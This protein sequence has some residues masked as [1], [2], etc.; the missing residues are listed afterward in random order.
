VAGDADL[1]ASLPVSKERPA[2]TTTSTP[3]AVGDVRRLVVKVGTSSLVDG[4]GRV[5]RARLARIVDQLA[6][7]AEDGR[8]CV[9]VSSGAIASGLASLGLRR[10]PSAI[11]KLQAAAAVGQSLLMAEYGRLFARRGLVAA[12]ILLNQD[13]FVRRR[14]FVNAQHTFEQ[15]LGSGAVP[16][17]NENDTVATEEI[18]FGDNDRLAA[19]VAVMVRADLLV[20]LSD[21]DGIYTRDPR[22]GGELI[23]EVVDPLGVEASGAGSSHGRG[24]MSSKLEA[25]GMATAAGIATV[26]ANGSRAGVLTAILAGEP[27]GTWLPARARRERARRAWVAFVAEPRGRIV[28]DAG[29]ER[30]VRESGRSL[31]AAGVLSVQGAFDAGDIVEISAPQGRP[32]ARG[33]VNYS[34][35]QL[36]QVAGRSSAQLTALGISSSDREVVHRDELVLSKA[37]TWT[38]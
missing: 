23:P 10:R 6:R 27:V 32:F 17:V 25:A 19:L 5:A 31:L 16:V 4:E 33:V 21:V 29:A 30:A 36:L 22:R 7:A 3:R 8:S 24:G 13:D 37:D 28:V 11:P 18:S 35:G 20:L 14:H 38:G 15:L 26:V 9:L 2:V 1:I 12:Q 34:A